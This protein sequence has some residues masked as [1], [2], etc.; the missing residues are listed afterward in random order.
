MAK[1]DKL[2]E[3]GREKI[4]DDFRIE[5]LIKKV[6]NIDAY[7]KTQITKEQEYMQK[8]EIHNVIDIDDE[9]PQQKD[10]KG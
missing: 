5:K 3:K 9:I 6:K 10:G 2:I 4:E 7:I 1:Y 8:F